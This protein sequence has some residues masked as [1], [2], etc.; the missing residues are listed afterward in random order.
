MIFPIIGSVT[1]LL[2]KPKILLNLLQKTTSL[3]LAIG[4]IATAIGLV[5]TFMPKPVK[6]KVEDMFRPFLQPVS[7]I[8]L[9]I[10]TFMGTILIRELKRK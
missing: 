5:V 1:K 3:I 2:I 4:T 7:I 8:S 6:N 9:M 10:L